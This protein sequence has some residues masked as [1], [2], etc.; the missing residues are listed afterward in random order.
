VEGPRPHLE[1]PRL[2]LRPFGPEDGPGHA[3]LYGDPEVTRFLP[4]G[5][6]GPAEALER[7][8]GAL[9][10]FMGHWRQH[11][12]GVWA[13]LDRGTGAFIGQCGLAHVPELGEVEL[14]YA[15]ARD[16]WGQG[17]APEAGQAALRHGFQELRLERII[18]LT[19]PENKASRRVMDKLG[20]TYERTVRVFGLD[21]VCYSISRGSFL[22]GLAPPLHPPEGRGPLPPSREERRAAPL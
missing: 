20:L 16:R 22:A 9:E 3:T 15:L 8:R 6:F 1:T 12:F 2:V 17:L 19:R 14:L 11:G 5:P 7:S 18:A 10:R 21:A 4:R 13:I